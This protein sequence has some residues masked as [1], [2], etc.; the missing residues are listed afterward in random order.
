MISVLY[1]MTTRSDFCPEFN[2]HNRLYSSYCNTRL[3]SGES[4][5]GN[6]SN[7]QLRSGKQQASARDAEIN[8][9]AQYHNYRLQ[10]IKDRQGS[11]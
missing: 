9:S 6:D 4:N 1:K 5:A 8:V 10:G 11:F 7:I 3:G 2:V